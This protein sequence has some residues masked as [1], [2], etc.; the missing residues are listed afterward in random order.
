MNEKQPS[1]TQAAPEA[2]CG[3]K[4]PT[5]TFRTWP[6]GRYSCKEDFFVGGV[7]GYLLVLFGFGCLKRGTFDRKRCQNGQ[8]GA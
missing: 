7:C 8:N 4:L 1:H 5:A 2:R 6:G 3:S